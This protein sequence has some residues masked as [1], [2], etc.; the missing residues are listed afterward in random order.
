M[1][2][3]SLIDFLAYKR[4]Q[5]PSRARASDA[6]ARLALDN[7][8]GRAMLR[9]L[10]TILTRPALR[11]AFLCAVSPVLRDGRA[12]PAPP[13]KRGQLRP[14]TQLSPKSSPCVPP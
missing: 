13:L 2:E 3:L 10:R 11:G 6:C 8:T 12:S 4:T 5:V 9:S 14:R 7:A 1:S